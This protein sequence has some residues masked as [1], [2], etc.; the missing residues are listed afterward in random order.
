V[1]DT[2]QRLFF[3]LWPPPELARQLHRVAA[4]QFDAR[5]ARRLRV[6]QI[7]LT[8][9]YL[10]PSD[11]DQ[12]RCAE[13]AAA[14]VEAPAFTLALSHLGVWPR[15][16]VGWIAP[17]VS[18]PA[19]NVLVTCLHQG[20]IACGYR[21]EER[22]WQAHL[23]LLR[24]LRQPPLNDSLAEPLVWPVS[25]FALV[26]SLTLPEGAEYHVLQRWPLTGEHN[27]ERH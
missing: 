8:L 20:L 15:P 14:R 1:N 12:R 27:Q 5:H 9:F 6:E 22:P 4:Q 18:P 11:A 25:E 3:A 16:R 21:F 13:A 10:G 23:T 2:R 26:E 17:S 19:L 7:H 24:K